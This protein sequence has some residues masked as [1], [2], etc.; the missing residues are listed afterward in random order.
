MNV[1]YVRVAYAISM[2]ALII[3]L[4]MIFNSSSRGQ[5][6]ASA[7]SIRNGG[8]MDTSQ[9]NMIY[10]AGIHQFLILGGILTG[11]GLLI[12]ILVSFTLLIK[13]KPLAEEDIHA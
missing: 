9:Y 10:E 3:G 4:L 11:S 8:M 5:S 13:S 1:N 12:A 2:A 6:L 7:E